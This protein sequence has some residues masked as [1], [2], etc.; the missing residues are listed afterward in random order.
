MCV[1]INLAD[2]VYTLDFIFWYI[3][4]FALKWFYNILLVV[5]KIQLI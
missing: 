2:P 3:I 5:R 1:V 4:V